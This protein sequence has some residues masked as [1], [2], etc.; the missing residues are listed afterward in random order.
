MTDIGSRIGSIFRRKPRP[1]EAAPTPISVGRSAAARAADPRAA[2]PLPRFNATANDQANSRQHDRFARTRANLRLAFTPSQPVADPK[3]FAGREGLLKT[4][5]SSIENQRLHIVLYGERGIGKTSLLRMLA[6]AAREARY[7]VVYTSCGEDSNFDETFRAAAADIPL[8]YHIGFSPKTNEAEGGSTL[9]DLLPSTPMS[10]RIFSD[11]CTKLTGTRVL[12]I[13]DEFDR[14]KSGVFRRNVAELIKNLSD[15]L[16]RV[17]L[18]LAGVAGDLTELVEHIPSIRRNI[19]ALNMPKM[20]DAEVL[21]LVSYGERESGM[22]FD[23]AAA[24]L[25]VSIAQG[26]PYLASLLSHHAAHAAVDVGR[27]TVLPEDMASA[28]EQAVAEFQS[29]IGRPT[30]ALVQRLA[31]QGKAEDMAY[32]ARAAFSS[33]GAFSPEDLQADGSV[34]AK[35]ARSII[36]SLTAAG[37]LSAADPVEGED[38][39]LFNEDGLPTFLWVSWMQKSIASPRPARLSTAK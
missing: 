7:I 21:Q 32:A 31:A 15:R 20:S 34:D 24:H 1:A 4:I 28:V 14:C 35:R 23:P 37:L 10:P 19:L 2:P 22:T 6:Q 17:Q 5:I 11:L 26:S 30:Q 25:V 12:I 16:G 38:R 29:R 8:L 33:D 36:E 39:Y 3:M 13:L 9:A 18:T 27:A